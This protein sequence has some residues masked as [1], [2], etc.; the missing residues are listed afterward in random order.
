[1]NIIVVNAENKDSEKTKA[2]V[3]AL[4]SDAVKSFIEDEFNG[5]VVVKF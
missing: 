3:D 2:L 1:M 4:H 5:V